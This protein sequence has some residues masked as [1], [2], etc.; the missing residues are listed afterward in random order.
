MKRS[1][2]EIKSLSVL[3]KHKKNYHR[4]PQCNLQNL[5]KTFPP[6]IETSKAL[7]RTVQ[8]HCCRFSL[9]TRRGGLVKIYDSAL[10]SG[11]SKI[12]KAIGSFCVTLTFLSF[13]AVQVQKPL[14]VGA[15]VRGRIDSNA[16]ELLQFLR[17]RRAIFALRSVRER[18]IPKEA[19]P[20][21]LA[22][23]SHATMDQCRSTS[24]HQA[25]SRL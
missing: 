4:E 1:N 20:R 22:A 12:G 2:P 24:A 16:A 5:E 3:A 8:M 19:A 10:M 13:Q 9:Q 21:R 11:V 6:A 23:Q 15:H 14:G 25:Q 7:C 18:G 17:T